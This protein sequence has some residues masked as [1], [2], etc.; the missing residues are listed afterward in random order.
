MST[1]RGRLQAQGKPRESARKLAARNMS[2]NQMLRFISGG[3]DTHQ[4]GEET[5][6]V[7]RAVLDPNCLGLLEVDKYQREVL[8]P[9]IIE[10][11]VEPL[12]DGTLPDICLGIRGDTIRQDGQDY[13]VKGPGFIINGYQ[14]VTA[15]RLALQTRPGCEPRLGCLVYFNSDYEFERKLFIALN[16]TAL[17]LS[18]NVVLRDLAPDFPI[19][20]KL[21][22][23]STKN[24]SFALYDRVCWT[25]R[26]LRSELVNA[27]TFCIVVGHLHTKFG[28][29]KSSDVKSVASGLQTV[30][31]E[32]GVK[33]LVANAVTFFEVVNECYGLRNITFKNTATQIKENFLKVLTRVFY[34]FPAVFWEF[35]NKTSEDKELRS[36]L[37][38]PNTWRVKLK[39]FNIQDGE[40]VRLSAA[41]SSTMPLLYA[42]M[43]EH[44]NRGRRINRLIDRDMTELQTTEEDDNGEGTAE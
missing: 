5:R 26:M 9:K 21:Y 40:I 38:V 22:E 3:L 11:L 27:R 8:S 43:L 17:K 18:P 30:A 23:L 12:L 29:T 6:V 24:N 35:P 33:Q 14:R 32:I 19:L 15:A 7:L 41:G 31:D 36:R 10:G 4:V 2:K 28:P 16:T 25:Q 39:T 1:V 13:L 37:V 44:L 20:G 34:T 42:L